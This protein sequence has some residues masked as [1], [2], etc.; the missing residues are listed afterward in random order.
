MVRE[1]GVG[2]IERHRITEGDTVLLSSSLIPGN[3]NAVYR[4]IDELT[5]WG[6]TVVHKGNAKV[7]SPGTPAPGSSST[8]TTSSSR[9]TSCRCTAS[10]GT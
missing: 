6:A 4:V 3:E 2:T 1:L 10:G 7:T 9:A 5:R 8:S